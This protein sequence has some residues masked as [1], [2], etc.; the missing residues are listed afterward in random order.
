LR[1]VPVAH[2]AASQTVPA[3]ATDVATTRPRARGGRSLRLT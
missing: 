3:H 2:L 1:A